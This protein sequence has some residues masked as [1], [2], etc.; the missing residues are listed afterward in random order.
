MSNKDLDF[1]KT[2]TKKAALSSLRNS[3]GYHIVGTR[4]GIMY[5]LYK[6]HKNINN[7]LPF[8]PI[9][10]AIN[11]PIYKLAKVLVPILIFFTRN[12]YTV[13]DSF[14]FA[15]EIE[16]D[17]EL[18]MGNLKVHFLLTNIPFEETIAICANAEIVESLLTIEF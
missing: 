9:F 7:V 1:V 13:K 5:G 4:P 10:S 15:Q 18:F 17:S 3:L 2:R 12:E 8:R 11:T 14:A 16:Q 6:F